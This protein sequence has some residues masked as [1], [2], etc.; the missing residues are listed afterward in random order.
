MRT[1]FSK[2][3]AVWEFLVSQDFPELAAEMRFT[4]EQLERTQLLVDSCL[5]PIR[6]FWGRTDIL[7]GLRSPALNT[8]IHGGEA[9]DSDHLYGAAG[10]I[11]CE[12]GRVQDVFEWAVGSQLPYRQLILYPAHNFVHV[13]INF[14]GRPFEHSAFIKTE[15]EYLKI[16]DWAIK[17]LVLRIWGAEVT[18]PIE[19]P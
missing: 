5:Q 9:T 1:T 3:F 12:K 6:N 10:D 19:K 11:T 13:S 4:S 2:K 15:T 17:R 14:P 7:S 8:A 18:Y 16:A